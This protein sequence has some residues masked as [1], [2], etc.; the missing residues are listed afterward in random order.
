MYLF[1]IWTHVSI[2][3]SINPTNIIAR[4]NKI[5]MSEIEMKR[6]NA[7]Y[8]YYVTRLRTDVMHTN[9]F[10][11]LIAELFQL[12][13]FFFIEILFTTIFNVLTPFDRTLRANKNNSTWRTVVRFSPQLRK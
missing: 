12:F 7:I 4:I 10:R 2:N 3:Q 11:R 1:P 8:E 13:V 5:I 9:N 6:S